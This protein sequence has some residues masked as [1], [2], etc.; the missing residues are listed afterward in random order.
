MR[1]LRSGPVLGLVV[2]LAAVAWAAG[3]VVAQEPYP[4]RPVQVVVPFPPGGL[5]DVVAR[6]IA[7]SLERSLKQPLAIVNKS[8][9]A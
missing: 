6:A 7:P 3:L 4:T 5:A 1:F 8:G 2:S 9:A